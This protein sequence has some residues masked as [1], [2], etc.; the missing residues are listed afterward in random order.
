LKAYPISFSINAVYQKIFRICRYLDRQ[1]E[2]ETGYRRKVEIQERS[3]VH[4]AR[5][6]PV[7]LSRVLSHSA[8]GMREQRSFLKGI[9]TRGEY[10][11]FIFSGR[12]NFI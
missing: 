9:W 1:A 7:S 2:E 11:V 12:K 8:S 6:F 5:V 3:R 4:V 10:F